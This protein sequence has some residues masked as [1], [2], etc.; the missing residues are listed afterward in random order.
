MKRK[1]TVRFNK[2]RILEAFVSGIKRYEIDDAS[3]VQDLLNSQSHVLKVANWLKA[4]GYDPEVAE[5]RVRDKVENMRAFTDNGDLFV[6]GERIEAKQRML[7]FSS[8]E[9]FPYPTIIVDVAHAWDRAEKKP[10]AYILTNEDTTNC[11][12]VLG[13]TFE[14]WKKVSKWDRAK[15]RIRYFY[16]CP[17]SETLF[18]SMDQGY[19]LEWLEKRAT[20]L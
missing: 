3:F 1:K 20:R 2:D 15:K 4:C 8:K 13:S 18:Y 17:V 10:I 6:H 7:K 9:S 14:S 11:L 12:V 16:E 19:E 5:V